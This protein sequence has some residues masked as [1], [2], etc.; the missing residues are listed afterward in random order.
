MQFKLPIA[1]A[2]QW[3]FGNFKLRAYSSD[4]AMLFHELNVVRCQTLYFQRL[5]KTRTTQI[6]TFTR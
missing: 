5:Q 1:N 6:Q 2:V 3:K 4:D